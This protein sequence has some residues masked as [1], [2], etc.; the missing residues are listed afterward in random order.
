MNW[1]RVVDYLHK[2][3]Q[4]ACKIV[5]YTSGKHTCACKSF[6]WLSYKNIIIIII[7][8][9]W[10]SLKMLSC[11]TNRAVWE[12]KVA[13]VVTGTSKRTKDK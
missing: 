2:L 10:V 3:M 5:E 7:I 1:R 9:K 13:V 11:K 4:C 6:K 8:K 12:I